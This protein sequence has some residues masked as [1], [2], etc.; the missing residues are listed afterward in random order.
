MKK[1]LLIALASAGALLAKRKMDEGK[2]E[3]DLWRQATDTV[4]PATG[5]RS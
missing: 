3:Q 2:R 5:A 1:I 4:E